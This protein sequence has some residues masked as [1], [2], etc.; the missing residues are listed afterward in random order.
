M[1]LSESERTLVVEGVRVGL[2]VFG[3]VA[4]VGAMLA[5]VRGEDPRL[6]HHG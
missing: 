3:T 5:T 1:E 6:H 4:L 2:R